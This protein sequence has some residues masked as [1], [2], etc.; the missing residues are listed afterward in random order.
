MTDPLVVP[1]DGKTLDW[2]RRVA[3]AFG[4]VRR[5]TGEM[6]AAAIAAGKAHPF[7]ELASAP[8]SPG[9]GRTY[10][11]TTLHKARTWDGSA[12]QDHW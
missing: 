10:Y 5:V 2:P 4:A 8:A 9:E 7:D 12:W 6:V 1:V 11:D 3:N